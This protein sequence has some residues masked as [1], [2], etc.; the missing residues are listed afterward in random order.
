MLTQI[1]MLLLSLLVCIAALLQASSASP[2]PASKKP[3]PV[4]LSYACM[5]ITG[6][7]GDGDN[8]DDVPVILIHGL[9][10]SKEAWMGV[11][12]L[13]A[14]KTKKRV[15]IVDLRNH[16]DSPWSDQSDVAAMAEDIKKFLDTLKVKKAI[17]LGHSLGGKVAVHFTL[18]YP[19]KVEKLIV[20]DM[21]PNGLTPLA[22]Q[23]VQVFL[24][25]L[26]KSSEIMPQGVSEKEAKKTIFKFL[27]EELGKLNASE[28]L[29]PKIVNFLPIRCKNGKCAWKTNTELV[30]Y[31]LKDFQF[32]LNESSGRYDGP[33]L[34]I[35]GTASPFKVNEEESSIKK[36]FPNAELVGVEGAFH[37]VH[38]REEFFNTVINFINRK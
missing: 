34:F 5:R 8:K 6:D 13:F 14:L 1:K 15:C 23:E 35:Y 9:G 33:T 26:H 29:N 24:A 25:L 28:L 4:N 17:V 11:Y 3:R 19:D 20:E 7:G 27:N 12:Q 37:V 2:V 32:L 10:L 36:L 31:I 38:E 22:L 21:R 18:N 30:K 16:G